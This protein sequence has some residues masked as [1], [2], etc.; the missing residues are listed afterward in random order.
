MDQTLNFFSALQSADH[1]LMTAITTL[2]VALVVLVHFEALERL[3]RAMPHLP[4]APRWRILVLIVAIL[5]V[6]IGEVWIFGAG[7]YLS[8]HTSGLGLVTGVENLKLLDAVYVS[9]TTYTTIGYGDLTPVGPIRLLM[10]TEA[11]VGFVLLT[12]S[13]SFTFLEMQRYWM[14][15]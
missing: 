2:L 9:A 15:R 1:W 7:I 13:A 8:A 3:N 12:W 14:T 5:S 4:V 10:G 6:H 11:L